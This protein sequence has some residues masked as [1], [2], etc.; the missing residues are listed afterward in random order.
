MTISIANARSARA[1]EYVGR[2]FAGFPQSPLAN[3]YKVTHDWHDRDGIIRR[4][5]SWLTRQHVAGNNPVTHEL[6]RLAQI[7]QDTGELTL[8]CWCCPE[9]CHAEVIRDFILQRQE[10]NAHDA[11][12]PGKWYNS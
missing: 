2:A 5:A 10:P 7:W 4:Y 6:Q 1:G 11:L 3:P 8:V 9:H 12:P